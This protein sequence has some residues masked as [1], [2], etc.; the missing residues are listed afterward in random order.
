MADFDE[1]GFDIQG[2]HVTLEKI[3][4]QIHA[5]VRMDEILRERPYLK[6]EDILKALRRALLREGKHEENIE[7]KT[8]PVTDPEKIPRCSWCDK[9]Q[10]DVASLIAT[11]I[12]R[13]RAY[14]CDECIAVCNAILDEAGGPGAGGAR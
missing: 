3:V 10:S 9:P 12:G 13:P 2:T 11:P 14:I 6:R 7:A 1:V 4:D 5:G 8:I